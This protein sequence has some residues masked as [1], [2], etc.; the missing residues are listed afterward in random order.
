MILIKASLEDVL[1]M[2]FA[3]GWIAWSAYKAM[4]KN[5]RKSLNVKSEREYDPNEMP[6]LIDTF[7]ETEHSPQPEAVSES[8]FR[9]PLE[10]DQTPLSYGD[11]VE[12]KIKE[13]DNYEIKK[14]RYETT[15]NEKNKSIFN[16]RKAFIYSEILKT[17]YF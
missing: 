14:Y 6:S 5:D 10:Q 15:S 7:F 13:E 9:E 12:R 4:K 3:M 8:R 2:F 1:V 11:M 16:L 17:K